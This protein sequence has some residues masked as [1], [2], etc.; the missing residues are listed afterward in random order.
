MLLVFIESY[1]QVA[2]QGSSFSPQV[3]ALLRAGTTTLSDAGFSTR[4]AFLTSPTFGGGSWLA[5]STT[6]SGLWISNQTRYQQ[7][8]AAKRLTLSEA[9][10]RGGWRTVFDLPAT[11][12]RWAEGPRLYHYDTLYDSTNVGYAGPPFSFAKIPDQYTLQALDDRELAP[13]SRRPLFAEVVLDSSHSPW[14]PLPHMVPWNDLGNGAIFGPMTFKAQSPVA[15][16]ASSTRAKAA[17]AQSVEYTL[18]ALISF[19][20]RSHDKNL[21]VIALG[22]HQPAPIVSGYDATHNV[23]VMIF[24]KDSKVIDRIAGWGWQPGLLPSPTAPVWR[25]DTFRDRFLKT[26]G[27]RGAATV[28]A[29]GA[30]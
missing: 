25:M 22:D 19:L 28:G 29:S 8:A 23:P 12:G 20:A 24:A 26:F 15:V 5:H 14:T 3:D 4:S 21:V 27:P 7:L 30:G 17:Y 13:T 9:F 1:G 16:L 2:V 11:T 10:A 18:S 6:E